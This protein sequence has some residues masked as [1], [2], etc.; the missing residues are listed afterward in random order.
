MLF[1]SLFFPLTRARKPRFVLVVVAGDFVERVSRLMVLP[2]LGVGLDGRCGL[3][4]ETDDIEAFVKVRAS[5]TEDSRLGC[6]CIRSLADVKELSSW[7]RWC[8]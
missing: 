2:I 8:R 6:F 1:S 4:V 5:L 7:L 3:K